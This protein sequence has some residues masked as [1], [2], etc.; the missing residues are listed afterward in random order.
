MK[1]RKLGWSKQTHKHS[2]NAKSGVGIIIGKE[3]EACLGV[4]VQYA[5]MGLTNPC[6]HHPGLLPHHHQLSKNHANQTKCLKE[7]N[8]PIL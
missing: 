5:V 6:N 7:A 8:T 2:Y 3:T 1:R 4:S